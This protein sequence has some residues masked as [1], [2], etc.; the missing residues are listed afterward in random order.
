MGAFG[1]EGSLEAAAAALDLVGL[2]FVG[3]AGVG[4]VF[5][6]AAL[7]GLDFEVS[8]EVGFDFGELG[9]ADAGEGVLRGDGVVL[10]VGGVKQAAASSICGRDFIGCPR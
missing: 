6:S 8:A 2:V 9:G 7:G 4:G 10:V 5:L 3:A 1:V